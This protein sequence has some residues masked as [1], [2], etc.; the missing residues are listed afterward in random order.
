MGAFGSSPNAN[1]AT[2]TGSTLVLQPADATHPGGWST[3]TQTLPGAKTFTGAAT[4]A[5]PSTTVVTVYGQNA[6]GQKILT[7]DANGGV[8]GAVS[9]L[10]L[11]SGGYG[12][13]FGTSEQRILFQAS[14]SLVNA[15]MGAGYGVLGSASGFL[16]LGT[17]ALSGA[18]TEAM[19][20]ES[21][22]QVN[23]SSVINPTIATVGYS[24]VATSSGT[25]NAQYAMDVALGGGYTG[26]GA[27]GGTNGARFYNYS[28]GTGA[29]VMGNAVPTANF[30][31]RAAKVVGT[32]GSNVGFLAYAERGLT[33]TQGLV[34]LAVSDDGVSTV[35]VI[36]VYGSASNGGVSGTTRRVGGM[37][38]LY[39]MTD[40]VGTLTDSALIVDNGPVSAPIALFRANGTTKLTVG[41]TG[42]V[43]SVGLINADGGIDRSTA[44]TLT[45]GTTNATL[46][47]MPTAVLVEPRV[48][49]FQ[50]A[51]A[52]FLDQS[53]FTGNGQT[54]AVLGSN[55]TAGTGVTPLASPLSNSLG[56]SGVWGGA[57]L[58]TTGV[59]IG[60]MFA[61]TRSSTRVYGA[62]AYAE[63]DLSTGD[64]IGL[65]GTANNLGGTHAQVGVYAALY[66]RTDSIGTITN[67]ALLVD[68]GPVSAPI[69]I[70]RANNVVKVT[71]NS[72]GVVTSVGLI[73]ADGGIDTSG[74]TLNV[75]G[76]TATVLNLGRT[77][78]VANVLGN[79]TV[80]GTTTLSGDL[81]SKASSLEIERRQTATVAT[82]N[83]TVTNL[84]T[85][86]TATDSI[87]LVEVR[88]SAR[89][90]GGSAGS[91]N[92]SAVYV[93][94]ARAKNNGGTLSIIDLETTYTSED[95][96]A[97]DAT[98]S[99]SGTNILVPVTGATNNNIT[100]TG[101]LVINQVA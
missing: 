68:N 79:L 35:E 58:A 53:T 94:R 84:H 67:T 55:N 95:Q 87:Y 44:S 90:T 20:I 86:A 39:G 59:N 82:T 9:T 16:T 8:T 77:S 73:N 45:I 80:A 7:I 46:V 91:A 75:A 5:G 65:Y 70:F 19:R 100:W 22:G 27:S 50:T 60:G 2:I 92:D 36:G 12:G 13:S 54:A 97:W 17:R 40:S 30:G 10:V 48:G 69:A 98:I 38:T 4:F 11:N 37:F 51:L 49:S 23:A 25:G 1:G 64:I 57:G 28:A 89:R 15:Y 14:D 33:R 41:S 29:V 56:N 3:G 99:F 18:L 62:I 32:T 52:V 81:V 71:I 24:F 21:T 85:F 43:T 42:V 96:P 47:S 66:G 31:A 72:T 6:T 34:G 78:Q 83:A 61:A 26:G 74:S 88:V 93:R 101:V 76:T 63:N